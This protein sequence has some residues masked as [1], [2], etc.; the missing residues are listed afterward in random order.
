MQFII[1]NTKKNTIFNLMRDLSYHFFAKDE[2]TDELNFTH[3][4]RANAF[5]RFH[6]FLKI[7]GDDLIFNLHLDQRAPVYRGVAA[8]EG[9]YSG[10]LIDEE[11]KRIKQFFETKL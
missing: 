9:E 1:K 4:I 7:S 2:K 5:P 3:P 8:H 6:V 11:A 10:P